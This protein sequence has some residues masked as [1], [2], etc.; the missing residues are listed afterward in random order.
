MKNRCGKVFCIIC[1]VI[2]GCMVAG[3]MS[4]AE[5]SGGYRY[6]V[7]PDGTAKL[8]DYSGSNPDKIPASIDGRTVTVIGERLYFPNR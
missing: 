6:E 8:T 3:N 7:L 1:M 2:A 4:L 5:Q